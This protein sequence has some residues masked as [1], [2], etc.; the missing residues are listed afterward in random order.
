MGWSWCCSTQTACAI[1]RSG[2]V[3]ALCR[4]LMFHLPQTATRPGSRCAGYLATL[5]H[6]AQTWLE[7]SNRWPVSG[8]DMLLFRHTP[9]RVDL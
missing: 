7:H 2:T 1:R 3:K 6:H 9:L 8:V 4:Q 5:Q